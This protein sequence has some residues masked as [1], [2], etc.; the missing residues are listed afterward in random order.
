MTGTEETTV[1]PYRIAVVCLGN[2]CRSP[3][4]EVVLADRVARAGLGDHVVVDSAGTGRWELGNPIDSRAEAELV[5]ARYDV[6][7]RSA[8]QFTRSWFADHDLVLAMD[9][10]NY[11]DLVE[12]LPDVSAST[13]LRM[14]RSFDPQA[15]QGDDEVV[16][17]WYGGRSGFVTALEMI[18]RTA[19]AIVGELPGLIAQR[20]AQG[21]SPRD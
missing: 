9:A 15:T 21:D 12:M 4:A 10:A 3:T 8:Q 18:E 6:P 20:D 2:I 13:R 19:E 16:D 11:A 5:A 1:E 17:P 14:F 7:T